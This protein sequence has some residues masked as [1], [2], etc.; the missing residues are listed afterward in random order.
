MADYLKAF[1]FACKTARSF[2]RGSGAPVL[3]GPLGDGE[4]LARME[5]EQEVW[6]PPRCGEP[7]GRCSNRCFRAAG[8]PGEHD[9]DPP[10]CSC[11]GQYTYGCQFHDAVF[12]GEPSPTPWWV[13]RAVEAKA[14]K[15]EPPQGEWM[16]TADEQDLL[17]L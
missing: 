3:P 1:E 17:G 7:T 8:H 4:L 16:F 10:T 2:W 12:H 13:E 15:T 9:D 6:E 11:F 5:E 14:A